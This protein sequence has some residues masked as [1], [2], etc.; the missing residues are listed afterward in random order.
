MQKKRKKNRNRNGI[1]IIKAK[2]SEDKIAGCVPSLLRQGDMVRNDKTQDMMRE[3]RTCTEN[4]DRVSVT[5]EA[6][7]GFIDKQEGLL[8]AVLDFYGI[9]L[10]KEDGEKETLYFQTEDYKILE[11]SVKVK[12]GIG[13]ENK[14]IYRECSPGKNGSPDGEA[15]DGKEFRG[16]FD[17]RRRFDHYGRMR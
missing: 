8:M 16:T 9:I 17:F 2:Q 15:P 14:I 5:T 13:E 11:I 7:F 12:T 1:R 3:L 6:R 10:K 4:G